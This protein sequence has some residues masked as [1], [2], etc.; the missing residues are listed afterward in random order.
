MLAV[1][2]PAQGRKSPVIAVL[3]AFAVAGASWLAGPSASSASAASK[4][5]DQCRAETTAPIVEPGGSPSVAQFTTTLVD[6]G[7]STPAI[8]G[9]PA[10]PCRRLPTVVRFPTAG[11]GPFPL[12]VVAHGRDNDPSSLATLLDAWAGAGYVVAAPTFPIT[13]KDRKGQPQR[14]ESVAQAADMRF[15]VDRILARD[16]AK[17][18]N[19]LRGRVDG[20]HIG[21]AGMSLGGLAVYGLIANTCC[22][23]RRISA[24]ILLAAVRRDFPD[25]RYQTNR[26]PVLL[27]QGDADPG[28]H[29][30][31]DA[32][33]ELAPPKW[34]VTLHGSQHSPPFEVPPGPEAPVVYSLTT[35]FWDRYLKGDVA[36]AD[37]IVSAV[38]STAGNASLQRDVG[39]G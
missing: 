9:R 13:S 17:D 4:P 20:R 34:F 38:Q 27:V 29:N 21:A 16:R 6:R 32:Y 3:T 1:S 8:Q 15:V 5:R 7:R 19:P 2:E 36:A 24:A 25:E 22:R 39:R 37:R 35:D 12:V 33:P 18:A 14:S 31:I 30:S 10:L 23:D 11:T 26:A 28:Y